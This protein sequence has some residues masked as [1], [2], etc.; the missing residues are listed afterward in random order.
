MN[1]RLYSPRE[2]DAEEMPAP[3][4]A[5]LPNMGHPAAPTVRPSGKEPNSTKELSGTSLQQWALM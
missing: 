2:I 1:F 3:R 4:E 5:L